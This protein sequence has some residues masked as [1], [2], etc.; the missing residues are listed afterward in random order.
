MSQRF[1]QRQ[2]QLTV[3]DD[4]EIDG[5]HVPAGRY[6]GLVKSTTLVGMASSVSTSDRYQIT[7]GEEIHRNPRM[8]E[9]DCDCTAQVKSGQITVG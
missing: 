2:I 8:T 4:T 9:V 7:L 3:H 1:N 5:F 6:L